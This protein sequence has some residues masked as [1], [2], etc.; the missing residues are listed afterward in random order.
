MWSAILCVTGL[1]AIKLFK[2]DAFC[3]LL[4]HTVFNYFKKQQT[5]KQVWVCTTVNV[6]MNVYIFNIYLYMFEYRY[7]FHKKIK[8]SNIYYSL[9]R[10]YDTDFCHFKLLQ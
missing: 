2:S 4:N 1:M 8:G 5:Q 7:T 6:H 3:Q 10:N 9:P